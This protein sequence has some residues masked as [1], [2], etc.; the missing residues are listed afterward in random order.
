[1]IQW[2]L[3]HAIHAVVNLATKTVLMPMLWSGKSIHI[4][5]EEI[6]AM[7]IQL[8][9]AQ[10]SN[11]GVRPTEGFHKARRGNQLWIAAHVMGWGL[12]LIPV[13]VIYR[14]SSAPWLV[15]GI[16][17]MIVIGYFSVS[18]SGVPT[19][20]EK[21]TTRS[22][23]EPMSHTVLTFDPKLYLLQVADTKLR[24]ANVRFNTSDARRRG[25]DEC[26]QNLLLP[27][28]KARLREYFMKQ[29]DCELEA[30]DQLISVLLEGGI[31]RQQFCARHAIG[32]DM[33]QRGLDHAK[34]HLEN[35]LLLEPG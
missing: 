16:V 1:M 32:E 28:M 11:P 4:A 29:E 20:I 14:G 35:D 25:V 9:N 18:I 26:A 7:D 15:L 2:L 33:M 27:A 21:T 10:Q 12:L 24:Q 17:L 13:S 19:K 3:E 23:G 8:H 5:W 22:S 30:A 34:K 31:R 6:R